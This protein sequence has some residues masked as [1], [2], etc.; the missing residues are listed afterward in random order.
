MPKKVFLTL[1]YFIFKYNCRKFTVW[2]N[3]GILVIIL[4]ISTELM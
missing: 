4:E 2:Q 1:V 3:R